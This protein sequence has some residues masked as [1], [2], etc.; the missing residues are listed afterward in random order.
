MMLR[1]KVGR[2]DPCP[3]GSGKKNKHCCAARERKRAAVRDS[4]AKG[5]FYVFGPLAIVFAVAVSISALRGGGVG[6]DGLER[7]WSAQH[8]HWHVV[9]PDGSETEVKPGMVWNA[10]HGHFHPA[11]T[12]VDAARRYVTDELEQKIDDAEVTLGEESPD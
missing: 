11:E 8:G 3:C 7:V 2:N 5:L 4:L 6:D 10:E 1:M 12:N 9:L